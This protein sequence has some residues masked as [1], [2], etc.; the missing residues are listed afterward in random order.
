MLFTIS[1]VVATPRQKI[2][3]TNSTATERKLKARGE[4]FRFGHVLWKSFC[5]A[6]GLWLT[7]WIYK[8]CCGKRNKNSDRS[9]KGGGSYS[10]I[11]EGVGNGGHPVPNNSAVYSVL[12]GTVDAPYAQGGTGYTGSNEREEGS[13]FEPMGYNATSTSNLTTASTAVPGGAAD[14]Y[15]RDAKKQM[16]EP[17]V[18]IGPIEQIGAVPLPSPTA[19]PAPTMTST[20]TAPPPYQPPP[21]QSQQQNVFMPP[22]PAQAAYPQVPP[23]V[24]YTPV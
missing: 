19:S 15:F 10:K 14:E 23:P 17:P 6:S 18:I 16:Q 5:L 9:L 22:P 11:E 20:A 8:R 2:G 24:S 3:F 4:S 7:I 12:P 13:R 1:C 21:P